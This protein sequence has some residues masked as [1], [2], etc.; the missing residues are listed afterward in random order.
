MSE[1]SKVENFN[2]FGIE[3]GSSSSNN[4]TDRMRVPHFLDD[5]NNDQIS[6]EKNLRISKSSSRKK[7]IV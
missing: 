1:R 2:I 7:K 3:S 4:Q 5:E 6:H